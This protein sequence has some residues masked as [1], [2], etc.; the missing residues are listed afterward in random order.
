MMTP[1]VQLVKTSGIV[2]L[3]EKQTKAYRLSQKQQLSQVL[4][5]V[6]VLYDEV[7]HSPFNLD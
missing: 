3:S 4:R 5:A 7:R 2:L 1:L 6:S